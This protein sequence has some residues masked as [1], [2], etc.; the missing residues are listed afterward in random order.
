VDGVGKKENDKLG[1]EKYFASG[2]HTYWEPLG[3]LFLA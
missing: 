2:S 3:M 1:C